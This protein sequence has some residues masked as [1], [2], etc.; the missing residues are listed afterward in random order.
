MGCGHARR[1]LHIYLDG[2]LGTAD[3]IDYEDH[4]A[5]CP[6]CRE[7]VRVEQSFRS[8]F[9]EKLKPI[10]APSYLRASVEERLAAVRVPDQRRAGYLAMWVP[11]GLAAALAVALI[12]PFGES[13]NELGLTPLPNTAGMQPT[14]SLMAPSPVVR[15]GSSAPAA[16]APESAVMASFE[17]LPADVRGSVGQIEGYMARRLPFYATPPLSERAGLQL[18]GARAI[19][20]AGQPAALYIY[21]IGGE[22]LT[23]VQTQGNRAA[24][25]PQLLLQ[26]SG[27][28]TTGRF[29]AGGLH[30]TLVTELEPHRV[31]ELLR[32][33]L[34]LR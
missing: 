25:R 22:R 26:R 32:A 1:F 20:Q 21:D 27:A 14:A 19:T 33:T 8:A 23:L 34:R 10:C 2:E 29:S 13:D 16:A 3:R 15:V 6:D 17:R 24:G 12:M 9:R 30:H 28:T 18:A 31:G 5:R 11:V 4:L 7:V